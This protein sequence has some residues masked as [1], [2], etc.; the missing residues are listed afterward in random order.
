[1]FP[2]IKNL[3]EKPTYAQKLKHN[4]NETRKNPPTINQNL[5][6]NDNLKLDLMNAHELFNAL[7]IIK[8]ALNEFPKIIE[9]RHCSE[10]RSLL[11]DYEELSSFCDLSFPHFQTRDPKA[12][13]NLLKVTPFRKLLKNGDGPCG[14]RCSVNP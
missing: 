8:E 2:K 5:S 11:P 4:L 14:A 12:Y 6:N 1:M 10:I 9:I 13:G 3:K 7:K